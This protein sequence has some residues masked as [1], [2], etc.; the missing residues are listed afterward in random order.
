MNENKKPDYFKEDTAP[1]SMILTIK[2]KIVRAFNVELI[3]VTFNLYCTLVGSGL[4]NI[5]Y[6]I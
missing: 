2:L 6:V 4:W 5:I 1:A 3:E